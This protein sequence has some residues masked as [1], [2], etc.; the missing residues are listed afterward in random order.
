M[1]LSWWLYSGHE[2][3]CSLNIL[4]FYVPSLS[5]FFSL[6]PASCSR[7]EYHYP[8]YLIFE[9]SWSFSSLF[10]FSVYRHITRYVCAPH[11][12]HACGGQR[13]T[14][15]VVSHHMVLGIKPKSSETTQCSEPRRHLARSQR[16]YL[17]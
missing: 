5:T 12:C 16:F 9:V 14:R 17:F 1:Y 4:L 7:S 10:L 13:G 11:A 8:Q 15:A 2:E 6:S 3:G